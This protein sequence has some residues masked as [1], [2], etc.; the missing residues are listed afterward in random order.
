MSSPVIIQNYVKVIGDYIELI[1]ESKYMNETSTPISSMYV[2]LNSLHRVFEY[3]ISKTKNIEMACQYSKK[4]FYYYLE[5]MEQIHRSN[6]CQNLNHMDAVMFVYRKTIFDLYDGEPEDSYNTMTNIIAY[7]QD[8][9]IL[10]ELDIS[11]FP[12]LSKFVNAFFYWENPEI[13][14]LERKELFNLYLFRCLKQ[15]SVLVK[16]VRLLD[17][18]QKSEN[19]TFGTYGE[20][21]KELLEHAEKKKRQPIGQDDGSDYILKALV[22]RDIFFEKLR[23]GNIKDFVAWINM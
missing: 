11:L 7:N 18:I 19:L 9:V 22:E 20:L 4:S 17:F 14:I 13:T 5:Y 3:V 6:L 15:I 12:K 16:T 8:N 1:G 21:L 23:G 10:D 2:G